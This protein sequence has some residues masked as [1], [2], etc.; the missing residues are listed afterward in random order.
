MCVFVYVRGGGGK[1]TG[2]ALQ[3]QGQE[4]ESRTQLLV[5]GAQEGLQ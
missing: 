5:L 4:V 2:L 1:W 3:D